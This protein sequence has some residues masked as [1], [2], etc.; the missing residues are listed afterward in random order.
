MKNKFI[1][2]LF[3]SLLGGCGNVEVIYLY[4]PQ[5]KQCI[6]VYDHK[7]V[8]Y[9]IVGK[10][11]GLSP[12]TNYIKLDVSNIDPLGDALHVCW[13]DDK[14]WDAVVHNSNIIENKLDTSMYKFKNTLPSD[15]RGIPTEKMFR[16]EQCAIFDFHRL[17][18]SPEKG[19]I[20]EIK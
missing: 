12:D 5:K 8:R 4:N 1:I 15:D 3:L 17:R 13:R 19:A 20:V 11:A 6:T 18:L 9:L 14:G 7:N 16:R 10:Q 2:F